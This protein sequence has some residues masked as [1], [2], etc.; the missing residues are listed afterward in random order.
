VLEHPGT[1]KEPGK[2]REA[3]QSQFGVLLQKYFS[4]IITHLVI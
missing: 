4:F 1:I 3:W 2:V